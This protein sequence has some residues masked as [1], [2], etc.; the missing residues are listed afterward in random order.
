MAGRRGPCHGIQ[1]TPVVGQLSGCQLGD[2][3]RRLGRGPFCVRVARVIAC[4]A[5]VVRV[6]GRPPAVA[7]VVAG[8][9]DQVIV[10]ELLVVGGQSADA[11]VEGADLP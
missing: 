11:Q 10:K 4:V 8:V 2:R 3:V 7:F 9:V 5:C 6:C 1:G